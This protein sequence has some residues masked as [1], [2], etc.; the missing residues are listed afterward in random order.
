VLAM[1]IS[2]AT[3]LISRGANADAGEP[4]DALWQLAYPTAYGHVVSAEAGLQG[5]DPLLFLALVRQESQFH[6]YVTSWAGAIGLAQVMPQTGAWIAER[7]GVTPYEDGL[8][9]RPAV[10]VRFGTW[11]LAGRLP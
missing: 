1:V 11:Y 7:L 8:L 2:C 5:F 3:R 10:S 6:P 9:L 4:P